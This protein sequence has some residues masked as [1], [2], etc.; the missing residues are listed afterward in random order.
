MSK[1]GTTIKDALKWDG[2][3]VDDERK[4]TFKNIVREK[5]EQAL[6]GEYQADPINVFVKKEPHKQKKIE[7]GRFRLI[8]G[9]SMEDTMVDRML[10]GNLY[11]L[12]VVSYHETP[13]KVGYSP[14]YRGWKPIWDS[15]P[16]RKFMSDK[17]GWDMS[18]RGWLIDLWQDFLEDIVDAPDF[19]KKIH[20]E[21]FR[22]LFGPDCLYEFQDG[23]RVTQRFKGI[24]KSGCYLTLLL[25]SV[26]QRACQIAACLMHGWPLW[27]CFVLGDDTVE[28]EPEDVELYLRT[29]E[30]L[31]CEIKEW[32]IS[33]EV[34]FCGFVFDGVKAVPNYQNK[35]LYKL[36]YD[37]DQD[38]VLDA[39]EAYMMLYSEHEM[40]DL[41]RTFY[42]EKAGVAPMPRE[43]YQAFWHGNLTTDVTRTFRLATFED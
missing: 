11:D 20:R 23:E 33:E 42:C 25:N 32:K 9:V 41:I 29:L 28:E 4:W 21:R 18:V 26:G 16:T 35:H 14:I 6:R 24:M 15:L 40:F 2:V 19:W 30:F 8:M 5:V 36:Y 3:K 22:V 38:N 34:E 27:T 12:A 13:C 31:G 39:Y 17:K 10:Y 7:E 1:Y 43:L 37:Y